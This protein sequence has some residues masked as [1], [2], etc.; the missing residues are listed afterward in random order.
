MT[1]SKYRP[2]RSWL[3]TPGDSEKKMRKCAESGADIAIFDLEDAVATD[4]KP[5]ARR[6][7]HDFLAG[8]EGDRSRIFVRVNPLDGP[9]TLE[10]LAAIMPAKPGGIMLPKVYGRQDV[11]VLD[12]YLEALEVASGIKLGSTPVVVLVTETAE[13]MFHC[14]DFKGAPRMIAMTW[15]A[16][17]LADSLGALSNTDEGGNYTFTFELARSMCLMGAVT[18]GVVPIETIKGD[19]RDLEGLRTR[20]EAVRKSGFRGML[21]IHPAQVGIINQA[22]TP[23]AQE[24]AEAREIVEIF[25]ANPGVGAIGYNGGMLDRPHLARAQNLLAMIDGA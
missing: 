18:A 4:A 12:R 22:F 25:A 7:V 13:S 3:F 24:I 10:D 16:E 17:D 8:Y 23:T 21:A 20:A 19:F 5:K 2:M 15:G 9:Y 6:M 14:G 11:E 1:A